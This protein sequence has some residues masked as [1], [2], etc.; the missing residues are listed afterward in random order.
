MAEG[1]LFES[2]FGEAWDRLPPVM[3]QHYAVRAG[4]NDVV[5]VEG[6][7]DIERSWLARLL[8][9]ALRL[10]GALVPYSG[11]NVPV[12]VR[13]TSPPGT[14]RFYFDRTFHFPGHAPYHFRSYMEQIGENEVA[15]FMRFGFGWR[16]RYSWDGQRV[17][18]QHKGYVWR[19]C[20]MHIPLPL[21]WGI[22]GGDAWEEPIDDKS[23][24]MWMEVVHPL[25]GKTYSYGGTFRI[26]EVTNA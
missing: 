25:F 16:A 14:R 18:L 7:M 15:E 1:F 9:P 21:G 24:R 23:F 4:S 8:S 22:G 17:R 2:I 12:M 26:A 5:V 3:Q 11:N 19:V 10:C 20:G 13:F 6:H